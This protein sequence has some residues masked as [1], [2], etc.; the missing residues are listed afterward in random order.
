MIV[1][2]GYFKHNVRKV[3][4]NNGF[5]FLFARTL[6]KGGVENLQV[7]SYNNMNSMIFNLFPVI[8]NKKDRR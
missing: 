7:I 1:E 2:C 6:S 4:L 3:L 5:D 8:L